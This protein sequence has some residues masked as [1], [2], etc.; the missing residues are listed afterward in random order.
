MIFT[1]IWEKISIPQVDASG[2]NNKNNTTKPID[3][4]RSDNK[5][6]YKKNNNKTEDNCLYFCSYNRNN[7]KRKS[8]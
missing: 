1:A 3:K 6:K 7:I 8:G 2:D 5:D 4:N